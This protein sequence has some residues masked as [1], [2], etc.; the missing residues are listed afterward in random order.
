M[1]P[2]FHAHNGRT[3]STGVHCNY[4]GIESLH[5]SYAY[6]CLCARVAIQV[7]FSTK[8]SVYFRIK[9]LVNQASQHWGYCGQL[10]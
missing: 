2:F 4:L 10:Y 7:D 9:P 3:R 1:G 8:L 6:L 5:L